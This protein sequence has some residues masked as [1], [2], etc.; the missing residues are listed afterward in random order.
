MNTENGEVLNSTDRQPKL[1][2]VH[3]GELILNPCPA[4]RTASPHQASADEKTA[5]CH[6]ADTA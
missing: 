2:V 3:G 1:P 6:I 5:C 4:A